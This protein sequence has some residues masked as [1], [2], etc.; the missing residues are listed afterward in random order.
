MKAIKSSKR[1]I[2]QFLLIVSLFQL[3]SVYAA[4]QSS[5]TIDE[6]ELA[7]INSYGLSMS[8]TFETDFSL[9][10]EENMFL[11]V[12]VVF[13]DLSN[14]IDDESLQYDS[15]M[16][17]TS[18]LDSDSNSIDNS[19]FY[20]LG[21]PF[22]PSPWNEG[23]LD[24]HYVIYGAD[25]IQLS[26][27]EFTALTTNV[28]VIKVFAFVSDVEVDIIKQDFKQIVTEFQGKFQLPP[29]STDPYS[30]TSSSDSKA[31]DP[32]FTSGFGIIPLLITASL[33]IYFKK[34]RNKK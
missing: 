13:D 30:S 15:A 2:I 34:M 23:L 33:G 24:V 20:R 31:S 7:I 10:I 9:L 17:F 16:I 6:V 8:V 21:D 5:Y 28:P 14:N 22:L 4:T 12:V 3:N 32:A 1:H 29:D 11:Y 27:P 19:I 26:L 25:N 18:D